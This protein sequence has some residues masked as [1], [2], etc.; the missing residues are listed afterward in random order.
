MGLLAK[1]T[2]RDSAQSSAKRNR[3]SSTLNRFEEAAKRVQASRYFQSCAER[4]YG[5]FDGRFIIGEE[6][7]IHGG[8]YIGPTPQEAIVIDEKYGRLEPLYTQL[9]VRFLNTQRDGSKVTEEIVPFIFEFVQEALELSVE[10]A[11]SI[12]RDQK[13]ELDEKVSL[14]LFLLH[15]TGLP[16]HQVLLAGYLIEKL[17]GKGYLSGSFGF[18]SDF[19]YSNLEEEVLIYRSNSGETFEFAPRTHRPRFI[20]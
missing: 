1:L 11:S 16:R 15:R 8:V 5:M 6:P 20:Q 13:I 4:P 19:S 10:R 2:L 7:P 9:L 18:K 12:I 3:G 17:I 14:D